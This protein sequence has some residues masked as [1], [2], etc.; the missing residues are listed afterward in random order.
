MRELD[1]P[2]ETAG[3]GDAVEMARIWIAHEG[4]HVS[5]LLGMWEDARDTEVDER[6]A[7]G[8]L[9]ADTVH[10]IANGLA[11][12]HDW[13]KEQTAAQITRAFLQCIELPDGTITGG[14]VED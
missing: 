6:H 7:W 5:L 1:I 3:D 13:D 10:H 14:Y 8:E 9:L 2:V 11:Q 4:L 12:S